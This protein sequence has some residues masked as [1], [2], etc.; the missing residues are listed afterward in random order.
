LRVIGGT[1]KGRRLEC[2][3]GRVTRPTPDRVRGSMFNILGQAFDGERV[4]DLFSGTGALTIEALSRGAVFSFMVE[5]SPEPIKAIRKN[6]KLTGFEDRVRLYEMDVE[7]AL[8]IVARDAG[9]VAF[10]LIFAGPPYAYRREEWLM[11]RIVS[12]GLLKTDGVAV[13]QHAT[14]REMPDAEGGLYRSDYR[15]F[16]ETSLSFYT[17]NPVARRS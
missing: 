1:A 14:R 17:V 9:G 12:L 10:D 13:F 5:M 11:A 16:G 7:S 4:L 8:E 3:E 2:A 6:L 15:R